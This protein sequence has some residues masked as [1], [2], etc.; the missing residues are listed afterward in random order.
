VRQ[1]HHHPA[2]Q[3]ASLVSAHV[4]NLLGDMHD[5]DIGEPTGAQERGLLI[6]PGDDT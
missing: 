2:G 5:V 1:Q 3:L 4:L 6:R